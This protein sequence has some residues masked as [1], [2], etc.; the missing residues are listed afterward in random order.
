MAVLFFSKNF[1]LSSADFNLSRIEALA[2]Q[3]SLQGSQV[4]AFHECSVTG[5]TFA[6][7]LSEKQ[8]LDLA[9]FI[10][11]GE[12]VTKLVQISDKYDI[13]I[14]ILTILIIPAVVFWGLVSIHTS[15]GYGEV[16]VND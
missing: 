2:E 14:N 16:I 6:R 1:I 11:G 3:A 10:P 9:E 8:M 15:V 7:K 5:Y 12:S 4:I 13:V